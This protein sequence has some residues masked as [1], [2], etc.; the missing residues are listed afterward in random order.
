MR[1]SFGLT[2]L[3][4]VGGFI[5]AAMLVSAA[6]AE[7]R[8][9]ED[10]C[11]SPG[12][13]E[14]FGPGL[15]WIDAYDYTPPCDAGRAAVP[16]CRLEY[17]GEPPVLY[18]SAELLTLFRDTLHP[19]SNLSPEPHFDGNFQ[20]GMLVTMGCQF[21]ANYRIEFTYFGQ[22]NWIEDA[23]SATGPTDTDEFVLNS[24]LENGE[25]TLRHRI[26]TPPAPYEISFLLGA[27]FLQI[28]ESFDFT[29][30][31][32]M[33]VTTQRSET[34]NELLGLQ[35]GI[36]GQFLITPRYW[37]DWEVK[38][39]ICNNNVKVS[40]FTGRDVTSFLGETSLSANYQFLPSLTFRAGYRGIWITGLALAEENISSP[41]LNDSGEIVFHGLD[42]GLVW[43]R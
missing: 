31:Q 3:A 25:I 43:A 13:A 42:I 39:A 4:G 10:Y 19:E 26:D 34:D 23:L 32:A 21:A 15:Y 22:H 8:R 16:C 40:T 11:E 28:E 36:L 33:T 29:R 7:Q 5:L 27:R 35:G 9:H 24:S 1:V 17:A 6:P 14:S 37:L 18:G 41:R 12:G 30:R 38:G 20:S 2:L